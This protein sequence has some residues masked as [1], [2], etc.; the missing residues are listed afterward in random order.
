MKSP[1]AGVVAGWGV[2]NGA[3]VATLA[4]FGAKPVVLAI[5]ASSAGLV[6]LVAV[7]VWLRERRGPGS[8][9]WR[10]APNGDSVALFAIGVLIFAFGWIVAW[11]L[12]VVSIAPFT[13]ALMREIS[14]RRE[15]SLR[16]D[17]P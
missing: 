3:L 8:P 1:A 17:R 16:R 2:L 9:V 7:A 5:Y 12:A 14:L 15:V 6:E 4:G 10:Q 11:P 13:F